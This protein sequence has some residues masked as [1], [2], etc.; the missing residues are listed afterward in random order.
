M[1]ARPAPALGAGLTF[2][3]TLGHN[4]HVGRVAELVYACVSEAHPAR[5][6][7]SSLLTPTAIHSVFEKGQNERSVCH[8]Y[9]MSYQK[10]LQ[11][12]NLERYAFLYSEARLIIAAVA[13]FIGGIPPILY[14]LP[15]MPL[16]GL[17]VLGLKLAWIIS[18]AA[19][20]YLVYRWYVGGQKLFGKKDTKD[21]VAFFVSIVSGIN[22]GIVGLLGINIGMTMVS[23]YGIF[24]V[25]G[26]VYLASAAYL[27][28]RWSSHGRKLF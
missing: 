17:I 5:V 28:Q 24:M 11:P 22:L 9:Y 18:G 3:Y 26:L 20:A 7:S 6:G 1:M 2:L 19:S 27:Y 15:I 25:T 10:H 16:Y 21:T 13:L 14:F 23:S 4:A 12:H 8:T